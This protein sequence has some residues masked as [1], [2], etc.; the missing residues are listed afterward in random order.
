MVPSLPT[1]TLGD[2]ENPVVPEIVNGV[3]HLPPDC[4]AAPILAE[5]PLAY[6]NWSQAAMAM[7]F[8]FT[9]RSFNC[10]PRVGSGCNTG[11]MATGPDQ[12]LPPPGLRGAVIPT[13][14]RIVPIINRVASIPNVDEC[15]VISDLQSKSISDGEKSR[16]EL[17][18]M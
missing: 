13:P 5:P 4:T 17:R 14:A 16:T 11:E 3:L 10:E 7:P 1:A 15:V 6:P 2:I 18:F 8:A 12:P 9:A